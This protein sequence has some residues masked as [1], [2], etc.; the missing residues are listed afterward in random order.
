MSKVY[1]TTFSIES[2]AISDNGQVGYAY[3]PV[4]LSAAKNLRSAHERFF[5]AL[6]MT[7]VG[8]AIL[9][10]RGDLTTIPQN[11]RCRALSPDTPVNLPP[12]VQQDGPR[13]RFTTDVVG[14]GQANSN[15]RACFCGWLRS[16]RVD[17]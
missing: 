2:T 12:V 11:D 15:Y 17:L 8:L 7:G 9:D 4:M 14:V 13:L 5:A 1:T 10:P 6:S 3:M 16:R